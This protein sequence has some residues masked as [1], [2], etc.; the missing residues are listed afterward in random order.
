MKC[1]ES[2]AFGKVVCGWGL[3]FRRGNEKCLCW[4]WCCA[5]GSPK[6]FTFSSLAAHATTDSMKPVANLQQASRMRVECADTRATTQSP[7]ELHMPPWSDVTPLIATPIVS[8]FCFRFQVRLHICY[9][10]SSTLRRPALQTASFCP[11]TKQPTY[12][13]ELPVKLARHCDS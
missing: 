1:E 5:C 12:I 8:L 13:S 6:R 7:A 10:T 2:G 9:M 11:R 3:L 4:P